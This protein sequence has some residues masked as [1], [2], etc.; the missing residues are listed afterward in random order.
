[1]FVGVAGLA[2]TVSLFDGTAQPVSKPANALDNATVK[3]VKQGPEKESTPSATQ[4][5]PAN[6]RSYEGCHHGKDSDA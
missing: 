3:T 1:M 5:T 4:S 6:E 2:V